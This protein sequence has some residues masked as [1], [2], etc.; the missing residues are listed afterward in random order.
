V[1]SFEI[2]RSRWHIKWPSNRPKEIT[3]RPEYFAALQVKRLLE[4][5]MNVSPADPAL[6]NA[7][8]RERRAQ[9]FDAILFRDRPA[10]KTG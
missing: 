3:M 5:S 2:K 4:R 10:K 1:E 8:E 9:A 7:I 6:V